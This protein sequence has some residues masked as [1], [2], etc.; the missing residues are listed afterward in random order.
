MAQPMF[1]APEGRTTETQHPSF[2]LLASNSCLE[3][4]S[5]PLFPQT[6]VLSTTHDPADPT[7]ASSNTRVTSSE[8]AAETFQAG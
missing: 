2:Q 3:Q 7:E 6:T 4:E 1:V 5:L 8:V